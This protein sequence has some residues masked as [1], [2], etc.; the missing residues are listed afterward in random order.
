MMT[1]ERLD[2]YLEGN[3]AGQ[4]Q[5]ESN[6]DVSFVYEPSYR[7]NPRAT[8]LSLS[9][10]KTHDSYVDRIPGNWLDNLLPDDLTL[11]KRM[12]QHFGAGSPSP[13]NLLRYVGEDVAGA[14]QIVPEGVVPRNDGEFEPLSED[15]IAAEIRR[16]RDDAASVGTALD[17]GRWSLAGQQGKFALARHMEHWYLPSGRAPS[18]HIFKVGVAGLRDSDVAEFVTTRAADQLGLVVPRVDLVRFDDQL[19]VVIH[20]FDRVEREGTISRIHQED[21]CQVLGIPMGRKYQSD[22]GPNI[23]ELAQQL[24]RYGGAYADEALRALARWHAFNLLVGASDGHAKN[25]SVLLYGNGVRLAPFYDLIAAPLMMDPQRVW[26]K[27][28]MAMKFAG[29][30]SFRGDLHNRIVVQSQEL[31]IDPDWYVAEAN[32]MKAGLA[33]AFTT[34]LSEAEE[35]LGAT[36]VTAIMR[37][38]AKQW[39]EL[40]RR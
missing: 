1:H 25:V 29:D 14:V 34:A 15:K 12:A 4:F 40:T 3:L 21:M 36:T 6:G 27:F 10:P 16:I 22:G 26:Y 31:G 32:E 8:P 35:S 5:R 19:A 38:R 18:T 9:M 2:A 28:K 7:L 39:F 11:R 24:R 17:S 33:Q 13:F 23:R 20:R 30:Y 37:S